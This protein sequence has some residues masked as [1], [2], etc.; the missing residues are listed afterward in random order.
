MHECNLIYSNFNS[1]NK[2]ETYH[3][4]LLIIMFETLGNVFEFHFSCL[5]LQDANDYRFFKL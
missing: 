5:K 2:F 3:F 1:L 4:S